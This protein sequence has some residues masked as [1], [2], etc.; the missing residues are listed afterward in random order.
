M[1]QNYVTNRLVKELVDKNQKDYVPPEE[2]EQEEEVLTGNIGITVKDEEKNPIQGVKGVLSKNG[3]ETDF[4]C[5]TGQAGGC[6]IKDVP[7]GNY[8]IEFT[9]EGYITQTKDITINSDSLVLE[10]TLELTG[11]IASGGQMTEEEGEF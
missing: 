2:E 5:T 1:N 9:K 3:E 8:S 6:N 11:P 10:I 7:Y 4:T